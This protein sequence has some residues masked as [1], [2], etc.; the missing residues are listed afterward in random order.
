MV[1]FKR[2]IF[3]FM[4]LN[5]FDM[6]SHYLLLYWLKLLLLLLIKFTCGKNPT[7]GKWVSEFEKSYLLN[8]L[9]YFKKF[10]EIDHKQ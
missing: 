2:D 8:I 5:K 3:Y 4:L 6:K 7:R 10:D 9:Y 1:E